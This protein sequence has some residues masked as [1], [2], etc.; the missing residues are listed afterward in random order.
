MLK[1]SAVRKRINGCFRGLN[2]SRGSGNAHVSGDNN[3][4]TF[5]PIYVSGYYCNKTLLSKNIGG[6]GI[7]M[8][9]DYVFGKY[10]TYHPK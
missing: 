5:T 1:L 4:L 3:Q 6:L 9:Q 2:F 10:L 8:Q 7:A